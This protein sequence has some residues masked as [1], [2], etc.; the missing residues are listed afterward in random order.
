M[1]AAVARKA[2]CRR[3][4][5]RAHMISSRKPFT[6][7]SRTPGTPLSKDRLSF[8][9]HE[10]FACPGKCKSRRH[11]APTSLGCG[12]LSPIE[13]PSNRLRMPPC[14]FGTWDAVCGQLHRHL[15]Q[16]HASVSEF[17]KYGCEPVLGRTTLR[18]TFD[19]TGRRV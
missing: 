8:C 15:P 17:C 14:A 12:A 18:A 2:K 4:T 7:R 19:R 16:R 13:H 6:T 1:V 9:P 5:W 11:R 10:G 3:R